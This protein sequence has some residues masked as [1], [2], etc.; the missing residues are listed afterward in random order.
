MLGLT[1]VHRQENNS[2]FSARRAM[3]FWIGFVL[4]LS[5]GGS[6]IP[7]QGEASVADILGLGLPFTRN[8]ILDF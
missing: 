3:G 2:C 5:L 1:F 8:L 7:T 6:L 4:L